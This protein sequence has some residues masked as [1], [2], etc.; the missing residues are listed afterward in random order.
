MYSPVV[1]PFADTQGGDHRILGR[2][3]RL[4]VRM[5]SEEVG[6]RVHQPC[7]VQGHY[8]AEGSSNPQ[9][10]QEGFP[11]ASQGNQGWT[12]EAY[13]QAQPGFSIVLK[14][15][16]GVGF[17]VGK[18]QL[19]PRFYHLVRARAATVRGGLRAVGETWSAGLG[20]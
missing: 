6:G 15:D 11:P 5:I 10:V 19:T 3:G 9:A 7:G 20:Y 14:H 8:E 12:Q 4:I 13:E 17:E 1:P 2:P 18:V 16:N